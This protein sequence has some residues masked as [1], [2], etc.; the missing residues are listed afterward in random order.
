MNNEINK[1][2][3][4]K[5]VEIS[6]QIK[7]NF[8]RR[9]I[10]IPVKNDDGT[11]SLGNYLVV[12]NNTFYSILD[13]SNKPVVEKINLPQTAVILANNLAL[14]KFLDTSILQKDRS[15][16]YAAFEEQ[17]QTK[18]ARSKTTNRDIHIIKATNAKLK[19]DYHKKDIDR[20]FEKLRKFV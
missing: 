16:G 13:Y 10:A 4:H 5:V 14:G 6:T 9:G 19:K 8:Q 20:S 12:K 1:D 17:L 15:Y 2:L 3:Y 18:L 11:I 7:N